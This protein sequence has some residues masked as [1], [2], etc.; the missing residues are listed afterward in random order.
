VIKY[1]KRGAP[2]ALVIAL[3]GAAPASALIE[4]GNIGALPANPYP[5]QPGVTVYGTLQ[6]NQPPGPGGTPQDY[7]KFT[8]AN[9]GET[10]EFTD[11]NTTTGINPNT[12]AQ[13]CPVYMSL[14][15]SNFKDPG[16]VSAG[17]FATYGDTEVFDWTFQSPGTYYMVMESDG[18][19][20][21]S[22]AAR[23]RI[24]SPR[25]CKHNCVTTVPPLVRFVRVLPKQ[26]GTSVKTALTLGQETR[27][28]RVALL[29]G[30]H[31]KSI[32]SQKRAPLGPGRHK[33]KLSLPGT[34]QQMLKAKHK[35]SLVVRITVRGNSGATQTLN[36]KVTLTP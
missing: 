25:S 12:C 9:A 7:L 32:A 29:Y 33:F 16:G 27:S 19:T 31:L 18:D 13:Y 28:V 34:Y 1:F 23:Y 17:T 8:V 3:V 2:A 35:L 24:A 26:H 22:Y 36:R 30:K 4:P 6:T 11:Q 21:L 20:T 5:T 10:I 14:V 15:D